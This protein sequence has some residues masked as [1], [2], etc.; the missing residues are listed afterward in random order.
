M[1]LRYVLLLF[2]LICAAQQG[3]EIGATTDDGRRVVLRPDGTWVPLTKPVEAVAPAATGRYSK[4]AGATRKV[5]APVGDFVLW[6]DPARWSESKREPGRIVFQHRNGQAYAMFIAD[7]LSVPTDAMKNTVLVNARK[8]DPDIH[9]VSEE[10]RNVNGRDVLCL[11][12]QGKV[13]GLPFQYYG[14]YYGGSSGNVQLVTYTLQS[15]FA[16][17]EQDFADLLN[18]LVVSDKPVQPW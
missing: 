8:A 10:K 14:Y 5:A 1:R 11:Q 12:L 15:A 2:P 7:P 6:V 4:P 18:G 13:Q 9:I 16:A 3:K 17:N